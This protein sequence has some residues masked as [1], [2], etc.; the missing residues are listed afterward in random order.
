MTE[1]ENELRNRGKESNFESKIDI[2][3]TALTFQDTLN[4]SPLTQ[5]GALIEAKVSHEAMSN[6]AKE[7]LAPED[8]E[9]FADKAILANMFVMLIAGHETTGTALIVV[10]TQLALDPA[11]QR[12]IQTD[13]DE[14]FGDR[15]SSSWNLYTDVEKTF[16]GTLGATIN[17]G[18]CCFHLTF[19]G[20][21]L[22]IDMVSMLTCKQFCVY[23]RRQISFPKAPCSTSHRRFSVPITNS[24]FRGIQPFKLL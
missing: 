22:E 14:I 4:K 20:L 10:L 5:E 13:L 8:K 11:W 12:R 15:P 9:V 6:A 7:G 24:Q 19:G 21:S 2:M 16:D 1:K 3:S 18:K 23:M 17:E